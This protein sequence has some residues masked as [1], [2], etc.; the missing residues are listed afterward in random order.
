MKSRV[1]GVSTCVV[2]ACTELDW[3]ILVSSVSLT[4]NVES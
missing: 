3:D 1:S 2:V 4:V